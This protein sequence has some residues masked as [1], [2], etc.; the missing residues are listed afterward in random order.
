MPQLPVAFIKTISELY[1]ERGQIWLNNLPNLLAELAE[2]WQLQMFD[3]VPNLSYNYVAP[4]MQANGTPA[5]LKLG[6][7]SNDFACEVAA[8]EWYAGRS[9]CHLLR[10]DH[11]QGAMLLERFQPGTTLT[12]LEDDEAATQ[13][14]AEVMRQLWQ[15]AP[16]THSFPTVAAWAQGFVRLRD[17]FAG[18]TGPFPVAMVTKAERLYRELLASSAPAMLLHGDL[19]H[20]NILRAE[21]APWLAIDPK[22]LVGEPAYEVGALLRNPG[23]RVAS[24]ANPRALTTRRVAILADALAIDAQRIAAWGYA[25]AVL[26]AWWMYEDHAGYYDASTM[27]YAELLEK[28]T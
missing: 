10:V 28:L 22:G 25:Q 1:G 19:H 11:Q 13:I 26:S 12:M 14:A 17:T 9:I 15:P 16:A 21:R 24:S 5:I 7:V 18:G 6:P 23:D 20:D 4:V 2:R 27:F 3:H 8:L